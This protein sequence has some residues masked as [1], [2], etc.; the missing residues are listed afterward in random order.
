MEWIKLV[1]VADICN[2][3]VKFFE[4]T[5]KYIATADVQNN[6]IVSFEN[7]TYSSKPSRANLQINDGCII[8][9]KMKDTNKVLLISDKQSKNIYSTGFC[10]LKPKKN[11]R[12]EYLNLILKT[13]MFQNQKNKYAKGAIQKAINNAGIEKIIVP[14]FSIETQMKIV[15]ILNIAESLIK[16]RKKQI[17]LLDELLKSIFYDMFGDPISNPKHWDK[18]QLGTIS[19]FKNGINFNSTDSGILQKI[20]GVG[21]FKNKN[22]IDDFSQM[23]SIS[24]SKKLDDAYMLKDGD[25][26]FVRSNGNKNFVGRNV[27]VYLNGEEVT[28]S[29]FCIRCRI[30]SDTQNVEFTN[31]FLSLKDVKKALLGDVRGANIQNLN[32]TMLSNIELINPPIELQDEFVYKVKTIENQKKRLYQSLIELEN[33]FNS[34]I[35]KAF[36]GELIDE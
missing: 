6:N 19:T 12:S 4:G 21:D 23:E 2:N 32:Q 35:Q 29:G 28:F 25:I 13:E 24:I 7:V 10:A 33:N 27:I 3:S 8:F 15:E 11:I 30:K 22:R 34:I 1:D 18:I 5:K 26:V 31:Y 20:L 16:K 36:D 9:A 17:E 14:I